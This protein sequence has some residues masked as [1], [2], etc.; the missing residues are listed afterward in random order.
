MKREIKKTTEEEYKEKQD[1]IEKL[2]NGE[3]YLGL[4]DLDKVIEFI[5]NLKNN[6]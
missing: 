6:K 4:D 1:I 5:R 3:N 2:I